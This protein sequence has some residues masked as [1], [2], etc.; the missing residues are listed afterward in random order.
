MNK[1]NTFLILYWIIA[2]FYLVADT[3]GWEY[4]TMATKPMLLSTLLFYFSSNCT[5]KNS[6][7]SKVIFA[8]LIFSFLGDTLL[9]FDGTLFF[10]LGL[11]HFLVTHLFYTRAFLEIKKT[12]LV[13]LFVDQKIA[14]LLFIGFLVGFTTYLWPDL[15]DLRWPVLIYSAVISL[16]GLTA[17]NVKGVIPNKI[18]ILI[19]FGALLF[20]FS[21]SMIALNKFK[22]TQLNLPFPGLMVM[23]PYIVAQWMIVEGSILWQQKSKMR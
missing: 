15:N 11:L 18:F 4:L 13:T 10:I 8:A 9:L 6:S 5:N 1:K 20:M 22:N 12:K 7:F 16:M 19:F 21:D 23:I 2:L 17:Y 3:S 14:L